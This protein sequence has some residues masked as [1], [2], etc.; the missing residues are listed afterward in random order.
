MREV[1][2]LSRIA[3][4][5]TFFYKQTKNRKIFDPCSVLDCLQNVYPL[6][7]KSEFIFCSVFTEQCTV[8]RLAE[9]AGL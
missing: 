2:G 1:D 4:H 5:G 7:S 9:H 6:A 8:Y 3:S